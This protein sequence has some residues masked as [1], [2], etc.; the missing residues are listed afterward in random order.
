VPG[1]I[2]NGFM[3]CTA[4][5]AL[6]HQIWAPVLL[7]VFLVLLSDIKV[8]QN[9]YVFLFFGIFLV[10]IMQPQLFLI[11]VLIYFIWFLWNLKAIGGADV[12]LL[13]A[14]LLVI[15]DP[16]IILPIALFGGIQGIIA[17]IRK[18]KEIP[19]VVSIFGGTVI[20]TLLPIFN[21]LKGG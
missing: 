13:Y 19:F 3:V 6:F 16:R 18:R 7:I 12:K 17:L 1:I 10:T 4:I 2:T 15:Q 21:S 9:R 20:Y 11:H 5:Y 8:V 14:I